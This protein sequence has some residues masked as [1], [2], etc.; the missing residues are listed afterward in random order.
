MG[1]ERE[2]A[3]TGPAAL[4]LMDPDRIHEAEELAMR[5]NIPLVTDSDELSEEKLILRLDQDGLS[6][7]LEDKLLKGDFTGMQKRL[8]TG[9]LQRE[10]LVKAVRIRGKASVTVL[11]A[12]AGMGEDALILAASGCHVIMYEKD[13]V[14]AA[15]LRDTLNRASGVSFLADIINRME[16]HEGDS[17]E[18]MSNM[19]KDVDVIYLDP[20]FPEKKKHS[21][22]KKKFQLLH[23]LERPC[24]EEDRLLQAAIEAEPARIVIKRPLKGPW[25]AGHKPAYTYKGKAIRYDCLVFVR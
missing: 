24:E 22:T 1:K 6:L 11:D 14:I 2:A 20:M 19:E 13:P 5:L 12:A 16:L 9:N 3:I 15:L 23:Y 17:I 25:L 21:L 4:L 10:M 18:A 8:K 7:Q